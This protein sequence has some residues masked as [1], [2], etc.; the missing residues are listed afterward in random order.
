MNT[1]AKQEQSPKKLNHSEL[2]WTRS[3]FLIKSAKGEHVTHTGMGNLPPSRSSESEANAK[4]IW[5]AANNHYALVEALEALEPYLT[6]E[7]AMLDYASLNEGR[8]AGFDVA[9]MKARSA[10]SNVRAARE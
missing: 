1:E 5:L 3:C 2:P 4:F 10:L 7:A 8:A 6:D 9:S